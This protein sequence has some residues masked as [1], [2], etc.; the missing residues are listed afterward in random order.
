MRVQA[1]SHKQQPCTSSHALS[2]WPS[3]RR[4]RPQT[5]D[6]ERCL[7]WRVCAEGPSNKHAA[8][9]RQ[10]RHP[11]STKC[12]CQAAP[13]HSTLDDFMLGLNGRLGG[14]PAVSTP[15]L[16]HSQNQHAHSCVL[17]WDAAQQHQRA[18]MRHVAAQQYRKAAVLPR[19]MDCQHSSAADEL[20][21]PCMYNVIA[22]Q[23]LPASSNV[24]HS[25]LGCCSCA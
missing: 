9:Q 11:R 1:P 12:G 24:Q 10:R 16:I 17:V 6:Q 18:Y 19:V 2:V 20:L 7:W 25:N 23:V 22:P 14:T 3:I 8:Q 13:S 15:A 21:P 5:A 4:G